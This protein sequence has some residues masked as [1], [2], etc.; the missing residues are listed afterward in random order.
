MFS[1]NNS[2]FDI[3][4]GSTALVFFSVLSFVDFRVL[5][6]EGYYNTGWFNS[7]VRSR[8][9]LLICQQTNIQAKLE[10]FSHKLPFLQCYDE[11]T[12]VGMGVEVLITKPWIPIGEASQENWFNLSNRNKVLGKSCYR[13]CLLAYFTFPKD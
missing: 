7:K 9:N 8:A 13:G 3:I 10:C 4:I 2:W 5:L 6:W 1:K 12:L 11:I